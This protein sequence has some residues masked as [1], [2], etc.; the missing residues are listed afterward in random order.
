MTG[1]VF[2]LAPVVAGALGQEHL[3][4]CGDRIT[5][6]GVSFFERVPSGCDAA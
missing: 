5:F 2:D 6:E 1:A 3:A 4:S